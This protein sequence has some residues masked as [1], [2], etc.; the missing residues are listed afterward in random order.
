M[1]SRFDGAAFVSLGP[2]TRRPVLGSEMA[3]VMHRA[4]SARVNKHASFAL[5][6]LAA[7]SLGAACG[8]GGSKTSM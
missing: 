1:Y 4:A 7:L 3:L 2:G 8:L 5:P 6:V